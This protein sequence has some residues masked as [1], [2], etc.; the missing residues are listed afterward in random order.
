MV[1]FCTRLECQ[2]ISVVF[3]DREDK[4]I[5]SDW[6]C[7]PI[8]LQIGFKDGELVIVQ[9]HVEFT[10]SE[11]S[12]I[13][14]QNK[15]DAPRKNRLKAMSHAFFFYVPEMNERQSC[16]NYISNREKFCLLTEFQYL[17]MSRM[18]YFQ[19]EFSKNHSLVTNLQR[20][21]GA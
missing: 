19:R 17:T 10:A 9:V 11:V 1:E 7:C 3:A 20:F 8:R 21:Y 5:E 4:T 16:P 15:E 6:H 2:S 14:L 12:Q 13:T 18:L